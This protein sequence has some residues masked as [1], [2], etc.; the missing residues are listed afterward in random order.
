MTAGSDTPPI[1]YLF[2]ISHYCEKARWALD[3]HGRDYQLRYL[4]PGSHFQVMQE[5]GAPGSS[6]PALQWPDRIVQGSSEIID[7]AEGEQ[8]DPARS[9]APDP[10]FADDCRVLEQRL[11]DIVGVHVRR[12]YYSE[13]LVVQPETVL[14]M[15]ADDL[16]AEER[17]SLTDAW[18]VISQMMMQAMDLGPEQGRES[19]QILEAQLDWFDGLLADGRR[20]LY[21]DRFTRVDLTAASMWAPLTLPKEHPTYHRLDVP[22]R[23][24]E[25]MAGWAERPTLR[26]TREIYQ[27]CR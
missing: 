26:W 27:R 9:L 6:V 8:G 21:G 4:A 17:Q 25:A 14:P 15:F 5:I 19:E 7:W 24:R 18:A 13:A 23:V 22:P 12:A 16:E 11:D 2:A 1:F 10:E 3:H 20:F